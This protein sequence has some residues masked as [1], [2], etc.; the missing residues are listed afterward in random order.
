[1]VTVIFPS[2]QTPTVEPSFGRSLVMPPIVTCPV[3]DQPPF[4]GP[5]LG[6]GWNCNRCGSD[7][8]FFSLWA[9]GDVI[10]FQIAAGD[11]GANPDATNPIIGFKDT[12]TGVVAGTDYYVKI[13]LLDS[14]CTTVIFDNADQFCS[15]YWVSFSNKVGPYQT[16]F[17]DTSLFPVNQN[18]WRVR[19]TTYLA[20]GAVGSVTYTEIFKKVPFRSPDQ[21]LG[22]Q[23]DSRPD[24]VPTGE[25]GPDLQVDPGCRTVKV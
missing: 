10:P 22:D 25:L 15:D 9:E 3:F 20:S 23:P 4:I 16:F 8:L 6:N 7:S 19:L 2:T 12:G 17:V 5:V 21:V 11:P 13:E 18:V 24:L 1:M 14:D